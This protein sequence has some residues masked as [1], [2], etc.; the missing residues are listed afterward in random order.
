[1]ARVL[2]STSTVSVRNLGL[3]YPNASNASSRHEFFQDEHDVFPILNAWTDGDDAAGRQQ[4]SHAKVIAFVI[5]PHVDLTGIV[6]VLKFDLVSSNNR[7]RPYGSDF[8]LIFV[9]SAFVQV[10]DG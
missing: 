3:E 10:E 8:T 5:V 4:I 9:C 6:G 7:Y 1:M 2:R